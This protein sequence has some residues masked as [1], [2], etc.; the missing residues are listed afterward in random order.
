[1]VAVVHL[2]A[3][4]SSAKSLRKLAQ[5]NVKSCKLVTGMGLG[6]NH[7]TGFKN[8]EFHLIL[9]ARISAVIVAGHFDVERLN[10]VSQLLYFVGS[11]RDVLSKAI[12]DGEV[13]G[14]NFDFHD[15]LISTGNIARE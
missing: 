15:D 9:G 2:P 1:V 4:A 14:C 13:A 12:R 8:C 6:T 10:L 11:V 3:V 7:V 5:G